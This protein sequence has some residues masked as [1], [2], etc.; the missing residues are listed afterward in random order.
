[1]PHRTCAAIGCLLSL[2]PIHALAADGDPPPCPF[3]MELPC[4]SSDPGGANGESPHCACGVGVWTRSLTEPQL[5]PPTPIATT[6]RLTDGFVSWNSSLR[7]VAVETMALASTEVHGR[8]SFWAAGS[9]GRYAL[10]HYRTSTR[11]EW[12]GSL[13]ACPRLLTLAATGGA[14]LHISASTAARK[15]CSA[16][17]SAAAAGSCQSVGKASA[18]LDDLTIAG[19][20]GYSSASNSFEVTG[21]FGP[22]LSLLTDSVEGTLAAEVGWTANGSGSHSGSASVS[23]RPGRDYC[24][25]TNRPY[26]ATSSGQALAGGAGTVDNNGS[27]TWAS[28]SMVK[29]SVQ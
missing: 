5:Q 14:S 17:A 7:A 2:A 13:P 28:M 20:V 3:F 24:A 10:A 27:V 12:L 6:E 22:L 4:G 11:E 29:L 8:S 21:N 15:G 18:S 1:M 25:F 26:H 16:F 23:V 19:S 9:H